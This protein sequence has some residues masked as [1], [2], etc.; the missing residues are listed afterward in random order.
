MSKRYY[1]NKVY[2]CFDADE[3]MWAYD[4]MKTWRD[5]DNLGFDFYDAHDLNNIMEWSSEETIKR[6]LRER[7]NNTKMMLII[8]GEKTK[9]LHKYVRWEIEVAIKLEIPLIGINLNNKRSMDH[10]LCPPILRDTL[11]AHIMFDV[12]VIDYVL[13]SY[14]PAR[15]KFKAEGYN[16]PLFL[17]DWVYQ[18]LGKI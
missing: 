1:R 10:D 3:D 16:G 11:A 14:E 7:L 4:L 15:D 5:G 18:Q 2:V 9:N 13:K 6:R 8:I 12:D 17:M